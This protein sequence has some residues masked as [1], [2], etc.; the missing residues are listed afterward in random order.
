LWIFAQSGLDAAVLEVGLGGRLDAV[1]IIDADVAIVTTI[2]LDHQDWL[3]NDRDN[4]GREKAGIFRTGRPAIIGMG[5]P[6]A[7]LLAEARRIGASMVRAGNEFRATADTVGWRWESGTTLLDLPLPALRGDC[8]IDNAA[9]AIAA[10]HALRDRLG[11]SPAAIVDGVRRA[12]LAARLQ[13]FVKPGAP[14]VIIDVAH[15]PQAARALAHWIG[16]NAIP[17]RT[18]AVFGALSDKDIAGIVEPLAAQ[19]EHWYAGS[20]ARDTPRGLSA[21]QLHERMPPVVAIGEHDDITAALDAAS[22]AAHPG[23]RIIAFGSFFVAAAALNWTQRHG[24][25][26][27]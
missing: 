3:G 16:P 26:E 20:L 21:V 9:A 11:W 27:L 22:V 19:V 1:N 6:P 7:G 25:R 2:D 13:R 24:Y 5:E 23:D 14:E 15:N 17:G 12:G 10:L 4:I 8:Q 18:I